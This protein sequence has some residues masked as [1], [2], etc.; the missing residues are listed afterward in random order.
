MKGSRLALADALDGLGGLFWTNIRQNRKKRVAAHAWII[1]CS[2]IPD[3]L[4]SMMA[5]S[6][7]FVWVT[8]RVGKII[9]KAV[10]VAA[11]ILAIE[12]AEVLDFSPNQVLVIKAG[13]FKKNGWAVAARQLPTITKILKSTFQNILNHAPIHVKVTPTKMPYLGPTLSWV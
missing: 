13:A 2:L 10:P 12:V 4:S 6:L 7:S 3:L 9:P 5:G 11:A 8:N 1:N